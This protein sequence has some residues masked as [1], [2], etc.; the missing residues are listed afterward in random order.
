MHFSFYNL[1]ALFLINS[2]LGNS[3]S[4]KNMVVIISYDWAVTPKR[5]YVSPQSAVDGNQQLYILT[6]IFDFDRITRIMTIDFQ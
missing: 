2:A 5:Y 4:E 1:V 3:E 6:P